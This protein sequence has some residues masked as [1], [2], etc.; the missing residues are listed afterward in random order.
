MEW[1]PLIA[2]ALLVGIIWG[3][4]IFLRGGLLAGAL[5]VLLAGT[6]F[7]FFAYHTRTEPPLTSD[8][9]LWALLMVQLVVWWRL[10]LTAA[11]RVGRGEVL[12]LAFVGV[13][14]ANVAMHGWTIHQKPTNAPVSQFV[15]NY[16]MPLGIYWAGWQARISERGLKTMFAL[17]GVF[18]VYL[19]ITAI[20]EKYELNFLIF[21]PYILTA[22]FKEFLG[23]G[24]GPLLNPAGN[25][26]LLSA[27]L[28]AGLMAWPRAPRWGQLALIVFSGLLCFGIACTMTRSAWMG[29]ALGLLLIGFV[30]LPRLYRPWFVAAAVLGAAV[31][32]AYQW[33][34]IVEIKRDKNIAAEDSALSAELRPV[35]AK[36]AWDMFRDRPFVGCGLGHYIDEH[37]NYVSNRDTDLPL[38]RGRGVVQHN[39]WLSL[40]TETGLIGAGLFALVVIGWLW[41]AWRL[42][43]SDQAPLCMRQEGLLF[44]VLAANYLVNGMFQDMTIVPMA[45]MILFFLAGLTVNVQAQAAE[46]NR[47]Q[48]AVAAVGEQG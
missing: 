25:G 27:C 43:R 6:C 45:N 17:L 3:A 36:I 37:R 2:I 10:G 16:L 46:G 14:A 23:R 18:G 5:C 44:M 31:L 47:P 32:V 19:A 39:V 30:V 7:G 41:S 22:E 35:L 24:R 26:M 38:E 42:W 33:S 8:R 13:L 4:V 11:H 48:I 9:I 28:A 1:E 15:F 12:L 20:A 21:P 40:L 34:N 29:G